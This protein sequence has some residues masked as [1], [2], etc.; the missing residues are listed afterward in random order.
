M[1]FKKLDRDLSDQYEHLPIFFQ[2][3][4]PKTH[5]NLVQMI[6]FYD[7]FEIKKEKPRDPYDRAFYW[8]FKANFSD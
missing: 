8:V 7:R 3:L 4:V 6:E 2:Y 5:L 1:Q